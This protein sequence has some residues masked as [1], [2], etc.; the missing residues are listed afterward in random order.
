VLH[1]LPRDEKAKPTRP[2]SEL[3]PYN[4]LELSCGRP[5]I[6]RQIPHSLSSLHPPDA[7]TV[8]FNSSL[9]SIGWTAIRLRSATALSCLRFRRPTPLS[10]ATRSRHRS[11]TPRAQRGAIVFP[12]PVLHAADSLG[13][14]QSF[15]RRYFTP[16]TLR[17]AIS[18]PGAGP[19]RRG[20]RGGQSVCPVPILHAA[21]QSP[22]L[23]FLQFRNLAVTVSNT[24]SRS[25]RSI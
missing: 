6:T 11:F 10:G 24:N 22:G 17:R 21:I 13:G 19:S 1:I 7:H 16:R 5:G 4:A 14:K 23:P 18:L 9:A 8:S 3:A 20:L 15:R 12:A 2:P 25:I